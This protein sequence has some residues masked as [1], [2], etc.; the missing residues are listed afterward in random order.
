M[1]VQIPALVSNLD[2]RLSLPP[3]DLS[4]TPYA[5]RGAERIDPNHCKSLIRDTAVQIYSHEKT[6]RFWAKNVSLNR[7]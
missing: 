4:Q 2:E 3:L 1:P 5:C 6:T 7:N